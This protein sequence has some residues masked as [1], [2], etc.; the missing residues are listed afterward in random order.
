MS[1]E[2]EA[3]SDHFNDGPLKVTTVHWEGP[4]IVCT[5]DGHLS[6]KTTYGENSGHK[7]KMEIGTTSVF[8]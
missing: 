5:M 6:L 7:K 4:Y 8:F 2:S 3:H 1:R